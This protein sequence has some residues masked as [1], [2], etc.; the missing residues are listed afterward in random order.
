MPDR[1]TPNRLTFFRVADEE[2]F[3]DRRGVGYAFKDE[4]GESPYRYST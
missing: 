4:R 3:R 2:R 1:I